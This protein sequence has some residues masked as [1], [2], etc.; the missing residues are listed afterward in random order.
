M[1]KNSTLQAREKL[2]VGVVYSI[3]MLIFI[4]GVFHIILSVPWPEGVFPHLE[5]FILQWF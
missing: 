1:P 2:R 4:I 5:Q 3:G